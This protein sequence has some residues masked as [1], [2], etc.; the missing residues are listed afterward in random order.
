MSLVLAVYA[1]VFKR[2][3]APFNGAK[4]RIQPDNYTGF[5]CEL[6][7]NLLEAVDR[8]GEVIA[9]TIMTW[10]VTVC[11]IETRRGVIAFVTI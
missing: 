10:K 8:T 9:P 11:P 4:E 6:S 2:F 3:S 5:G 1:E 7:H